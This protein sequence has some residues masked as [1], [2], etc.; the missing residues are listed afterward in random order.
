MRVKEKKIKE[1]KTKNAKY[2]RICCKER[3]IVV[4]RERKWERE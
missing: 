2:N 4:L 3:T 1:S